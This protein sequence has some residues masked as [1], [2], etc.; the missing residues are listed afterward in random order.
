MKALG[1]GL[2]RYLNKIYMYKK[3]TIHVY[4]NIERSITINKS[5]GSIKLNL[6]TKETINETLS[7]I[8][9]EKVR[10]KIKYVYLAGV[11]VIIKSLFPQ[12]LNT[13]IVLSL[14]VK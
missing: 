9:N 11:H 3:Y 6:L 1:K 12:N 14:H 4:Q 10:E 13:L 8:K 7:K 5:K 2:L